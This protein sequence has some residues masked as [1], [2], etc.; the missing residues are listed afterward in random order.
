MDSILTIRV[1]GITKDENLARKEKSEEKRSGL[2]N[3]GR[4][5]IWGSQGTE[6]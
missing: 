4:S 3:G 6:K 1:D 2:S 5:G